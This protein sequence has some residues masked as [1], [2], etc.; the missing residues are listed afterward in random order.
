MKATSHISFE[1]LVDLAE[2]RLLPDD[3]VTSLSHIES[4]PKCMTQLH[5]LN[6]V[7]A[8]MRTDSAVDAP[9]DLIAYARSLFKARRPVTESSILRRLVASLTFDSQTT[10]P[11][12]G[13]RSGETPRRQIIFS[14]GETDLDLRL[15]PEGDRWLLSGQVL[16]GECSGGRV[17][18][19]SDQELQTVVLNDLCEFVLRPVLP[20][21]YK[22]RLQLSD[23]EIEVTELSI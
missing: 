23:L 7:L 3:R 21:K 11:A 17:L 18:L 6:H 9:R 12:F 13:V 19:E 2:E 10:A 8:M 16:S 1:K 15:V 4:C 14:A 20:G 22:V 5:N